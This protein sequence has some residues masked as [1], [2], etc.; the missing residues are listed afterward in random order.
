MDLRHLR[1]FAAVAETCHFGR[2][3]ERLQVAQPA[4]SLKVRQ[5]E[6]ELGVTLFERT[7][8]QV[9]LTTAGKFLKSETDQLFGRL[10]ETIAG[11]RQLSA[12]QAGLLRIGMN[13]T[14]AFSHLPYIAR[15]VKRTLPD[16]ALGIHADMLTPAQCA[17][18]RDGTLEVGILRPP[19]LGR[20]LATAPFVSESLVLALPERHRLVEEAR[21]SMSELR[22]ESWVFYSSPHSALN[23]RV[24]RLCA[25]AGFMPR[26]EHEAAGGSV[27]LALVAAGLGVA[28]VPEGVRSHPL[29]GVVFRD[30]PEAGRLDL[31]LGYRAGS[32]NPLVEAVVSLLA[33][34]R[35]IADA[36]Q[37]RRAGESSS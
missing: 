19:V 28:I 22:D 37:A 5:L 20:D 29:Q 9:S 8:R 25:G 3:A 16:V 36:S 13:G 6:E 31:V 10:D 18:L 34:P 15:V 32:D 12:G 30:L 11:V 33:A 14:A 17:G 24:T 21:I 23:A 1:Y 27:L 7:T 2:A 4:L 26:R 35:R